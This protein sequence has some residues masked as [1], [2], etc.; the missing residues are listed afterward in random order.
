MGDVWPFLCVLHV[1]SLDL[2]SASGQTEGL[3]KSLLA[4]TAGEPAKAGIADATWNALLREAGEGMS[5]A[6]SYQ[7]ENLPE[8]LR[9]RHAQIGDTEQHALRALSDHSTPLLDGIRST[10][11]E[12][13][14][15]RNGLVQNVIEHL[16]SNQVVLISGG[17]G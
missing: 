11:G 7:R 17:G 14:L 16:E 15:D 13:H 1:L 2:T 3:I 8:E 10:I 12:V 6:R 5:E 4:H 9:Q